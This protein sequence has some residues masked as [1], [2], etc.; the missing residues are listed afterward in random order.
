[1]EVFS[2]NDCA[3][4]RAGG[5]K[6]CVV[7]N[8]NYAGLTQFVAEVKGLAKACPYVEGSADYGTFD[9]CAPGLDEATLECDRTIIIA[10]EGDIPYSVLVRA[11]DAVREEGRRG[12][13]K[14]L[15][16]VSP[17]ARKALTDAGMD[18]E[19]ITKSMGSFNPERPTDVRQDRAGNR[20]ARKVCTQDE[21][22]GA[23]SVAHMEIA[24]ELF[25]YVVI[26]GGTALVRS[27]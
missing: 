12:N 20:V 15:D 9:P 4:R 18:D 3:A 11:M 23:R 21:E 6:D 1:M 8:Y 16:A 17:G 13:P 2:G 24:N 26:A 22:T 25:P 10:P 5:E 14:E 19:G 7:D 27:E